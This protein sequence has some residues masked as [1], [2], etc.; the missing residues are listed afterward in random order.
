VRKLTLLDWIVCAALLGIFGFFLLN[1]FS[2]EERWVNIKL[3][4]SSDEWWWDAN[5]PAWYGFELS[6][7]QSAYN[8]FGKKVAEIETIENYDIGGSRRLISAD[9]KL[10]ATYNKK[11]QTYT[12]NYQTLQIGK[13]LDFTFG[14]YNLRGLVTYIGD[15][16]IPYS[17]TKLEVKLENIYPWEASSYIVGAHM[18]DMLGNVIAT[19]D[20]VDVQNAVV[21]ELTDNHGRLIIIPA[22][23]DSLKDVTL[24]LTLQTYTIHDVPFFID[25]S[26]IKI[27]N[28]IW[29]EFER[30]AVKNAVISNI[31]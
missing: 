6:K 31:Y 7:G 14:R 13:A 9:M 23:Q 10:L 21:S 25:G 27:G 2:K 15:N 16:G 1:R 28:R 30:T 22:T 11:T 8:T 4:V 5:I 26:A 19:I 29:V 18:T 24:Q 12:F 20:A 3:K 17:T